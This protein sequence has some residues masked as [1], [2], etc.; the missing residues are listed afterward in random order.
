MRDTF[1]LCSRWVF[2]LLGVEVLKLQICFGF[3]AGTVKGTSF[4]SGY[5]VLKT[6]TS[7]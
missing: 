6:D 3:Q 2:F 1:Q 5:E 7:S 4:S